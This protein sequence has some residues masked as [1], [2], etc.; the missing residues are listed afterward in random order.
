VGGELFKSKSRNL[1]YPL[2][3]FNNANTLAHELVH[4]FGKGHNP[5]YMPAIQAGEGRLSY[6]RCDNL[7]LT[8][9]KRVCGY[10][11]FLTFTVISPRYN[12]RGDI[13]RYVR[14]PQAQCCAMVV[15][16]DTP[17]PSLTISPF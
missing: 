10:K 13:C 17:S 7:F 15:P 4:Y 1:D 3:R 5:V 2:Y 12:Y 11:S 6:Q 14:S 9:V 16:L 8:G